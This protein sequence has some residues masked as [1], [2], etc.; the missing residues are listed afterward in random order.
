[1]AAAPD[2]LVAARDVRDDR[3]GLARRLR[4]AV[5]VGEADDGVGIGDVDK[6]RLGADRE[7]GDAEG[8]IQAGSEDLVDF[9]FAAALAED[10]NAVGPALGHE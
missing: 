9:G 4:V 1:V 7:E 6:L 5:L 8:P 2:A 10:V 3:L